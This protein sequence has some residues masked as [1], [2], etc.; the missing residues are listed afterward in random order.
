MPSGISPGD[1]KLLLVTGVAFFI[2]IVLGLL[3]NHN[4]TETHAATTYSSASQG[5]RALYLLLQ[6]LGYHVERWRQPYSSLTPDRYTV[7]IIAGP[8]LVPD[9][10]QRAALERFL[11][12]GGRIITDGV[13]GASFLPEDFSQY[14][15]TANP[16]WSVFN[17]L[18]PSAITRAA[19]TITLSPVTRWSELSAIPLYGKQDETVVVNYRYGQGE[20]I[21]LAS[22][23]PLTNAG[24]QQNGNLE[25]LLAAIGERQE[26]RVLF[27]EFVHGYGGRESSATKHPLL[28]GL[29]L[30]SV[31][32]AASLLCTFSRRSGPLRPIPAEPRLAPLEFVEMMGALYQQARAASVAVDIYYQRLQFWM[33][34][35]FGLSLDATPEELARAA[36]DRGIMT[37]DA[38]VNI[39]QAARSARYQPDL[40]QKRALE[41]VRALYACAVK[42]RLFP[43]V[44]EKS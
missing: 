10:R 33:T 21:W 17:A 36:Q 30:Q 25:F 8:E 44:K 6:E 14:N 9:A 37:E 13:S 42:L 32:L 1:R 43:P 35:R 22:A 19:P 28:M 26:T 5:T 29:F 34:R 18:V 3:L 2:L 16:P 40:P 12:G 24:I 4:P 23:T 31:L 7:L 11:S 41:I 39:L 27:D 15:F 38:F 20:V